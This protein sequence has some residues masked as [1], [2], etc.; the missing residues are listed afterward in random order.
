MRT[1]RIFQTVF[2]AGVLLCFTLPATA[3]YLGILQSAE[4]MEPGIFKLV[5]APIIVLGKD[6]ADNEIGFAARGGYAFTEQFDVEAKLGVFDQGTVIGVDGEYWIFRGEDNNSHIDC[7]LTGG[8]HWI[9][10]KDNNYDTMG[11]EITPQLS[12]HVTDNLELCGALDASFE[13]IQDAPPGIDDSFMR[14]HLVPGIEYRLSNALD[15][16]TEFGIAIN[17]NSSHYVGA[18]ITY[19]M[20]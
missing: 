14:L 19:Y 13:S 16:A 11:F 10:G 5:A 20:R 2:I 7:S 4:T 6:G 3:Q 15:L 1:S 8:V 17:D 18:G 9:S 12:G